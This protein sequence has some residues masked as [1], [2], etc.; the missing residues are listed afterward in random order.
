MKYIVIDR[1]IDMNEWDEEFDNLVEAIEFARKGWNHMNEYDQKH[2]AEFIVLKSANPDE[3][4]EDHF[5]G[6][7]VFDCISEADMTTFAVIF[8]MIGCTIK[9]LACKYEI[10]YR[11]VQDWKSGEGKCPKYIINMLCEIYGF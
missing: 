5:D 3:D 6:D 8:R 9:H 1:G 2:T 7:P 11:T 4:A 10:P